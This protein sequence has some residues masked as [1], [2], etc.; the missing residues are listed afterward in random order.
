MGIFKNIV[1]NIPGGS[2][3]GE[4]FPGENLSGGVWLVEII[5]VGIFQVG[6]FLILKKIYAKNSQE[7]T[8]WHW[9]SSEKFS[10]SQPINSAFSP[11]PIITFPYGAEIFLHP[12]VQLIDHISA[13]IGYIEMQT[14]HHVCGFEFFE[15]QHVK[16]K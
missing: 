8:H 16:L 10:F 7:Y 15:S 12:L 6:V 1:G 11:P 3:L 5:R 2:F 14:S 13:F 4:N 9:S